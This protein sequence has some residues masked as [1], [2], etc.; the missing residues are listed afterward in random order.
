MNLNPSKSV[1]L[2]CLTALWGLASTTQSLAVCANAQSATALRWDPVLHQQWLTTTDC[3]HP[4]RPVR[5]TLTL[6]STPLPQTVP[7]ARPL[8]VRAGERI[9]LW[10][11]QSN[12]RM[13]L[14]G[15]AEGSGAIGDTVRVRLTQST[16]G[17][18]EPELQGIVRGPSEVELHQ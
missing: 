13:E 8:V 18:I 4:E 5:A 15:I 6:S 1:S 16:T 11:Q 10:F 12:T 3:N 14:S 9:R 2:A 7:V 17:Q